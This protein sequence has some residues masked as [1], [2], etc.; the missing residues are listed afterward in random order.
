MLL[1][2][3]H[4]VGEVDDQTGGTVTFAFAGGASV[5]CDVEAVEARLTDLGAA[6]KSAATPEH[7]V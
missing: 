3:T 5:R 6:W 7:A 4:E 1:A 2:I